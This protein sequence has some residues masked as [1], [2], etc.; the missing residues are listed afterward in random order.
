MNVSGS[1]TVCG[2]FGDPVAHSMSPYMQTAAMIEMGFDGVY[3]PFHVRPERL[4]HAVGAV[5]ALGMRGVNV[6]VPHKT[7]VAQFLDRLTDAAR[8]TGAV[9][10]IINDDGVLTGDNTDVYGFVQGLLH[11]E[12]VDAFPE[13]VCIL[14][15]GGAARGIVYGCATR[16]EVVDIV[17]LNRTAEKALRLADEF[18]EKTGKR[19]RARQLDKRTLE[20]ELPNAGLIVNAT[21]I[22]MH[23]RTD[24]T[25]VSDPSLFH[26]G[27]I[28]YDIIMPPPVTRLRKEASLRGART[29]GG[30]AMLALQGARSLSLWTGREAPEE[31]M[32]STLM[33]LFEGKKTS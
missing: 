21:S 5:V 32:I 15:A 27:Q 2:I 20:D 19:I 30:L 25:P 12:G 24:D 8:A 23:P 10:T 9:N 16:P 22:G 1:T 6:T 33:K 29:V 7:A 3:V 28:V 26:S 31:F 4:E 13:R 11:E 14:G 18:A 17:I